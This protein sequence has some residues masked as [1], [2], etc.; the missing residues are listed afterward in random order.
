MKEFISN[1]NEIKAR[2]RSQMEK[3]A[4]TNSY[5]A[6]RESVVNVLNQVLAT[7]LVCTLRYKRHYYTA[8][9]MNSEAVKEEFLQHAQEEQQH[10]DWVATRIIQL[11]GEPDFNPQGLSS[12]S[13]SEYAEGHNLV[14][15]I[16]EDLFAERIA[17]ESYSEIVRWIGDKDPTTRRLI[18]DILKTE[19]EHAEDLKTLLEKNS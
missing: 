14:E 6:D 2:A 16:K 9:G 13:H 4:V 18:E 3:G 1:L 11:N 12:R 7:E 5:K 15:M 17:I 8:S 19:E 10:A